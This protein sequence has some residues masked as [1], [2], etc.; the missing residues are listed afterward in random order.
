MSSKVQPDGCRPEPIV[1]GRFL[2]LK[3]VVWLPTCLVV[4]V[5]VAWA[6]VVAQSYVAPLV[7][8]PLLVGVGLGALIVGMMRL[9][10]VG[11]RR[12][13]L[14]GTVLAVAVTV[15]GQHYFTYIAAFH[16]TRGKAKLSEPLRRAFSDLVRDSTPS[17][18]EFMRQRATHGR[19]LPGDYRAR[20][21]LA[22]VTWAVDGLL[23]L[24]AASQPRAR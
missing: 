18:A 1:R 21:W 7:L 15:T 24:T 4:G 16:P 3:L 19:L 12:T 8:F 17:F 9:G 2:W 22:W 20:G 10:Q 23:V 11:N 6:A 14:L 13:V 5:L